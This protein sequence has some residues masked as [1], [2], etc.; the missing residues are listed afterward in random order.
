MPPIPRRS[1]S[2]QGGGLGG[3][4]RELCPLAKVYYVN[5]E[6]AVFEL[7]AQPP[8]EALQ[9]MHI[10]VSRRTAILK[11][12]GLRVSGGGGCSRGQGDRGR[13]EHCLCLGLDT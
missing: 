4:G 10:E 5:S 3:R 11:W 6:R 7:L 8:L 12:Q 9:G 2:G 1:S 13:G